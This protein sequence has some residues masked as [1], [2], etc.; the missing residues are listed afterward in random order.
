MHCADISVSTKPS[1][2]PHVWVSPIRLRQGE[3]LVRCPNCLAR[4]AAKRPRPSTLSRAKCLAC[5]VT[6]STRLGDK[7][8][9]KC[10]FS[11]RRVKKNL[12]SFRRSLECSRMGLLFRRGMLWMRGLCYYS[13]DVTLLNFAAVR[14]P[15]ITSTAKP[16]M[17]NKTSSPKTNE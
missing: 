3:S 7:N 5:S 11:A 14:S 1:A 8:V 16:A 4:S 9:P 12:V 10:S 13:A 17:P 15:T 6:S 2:T